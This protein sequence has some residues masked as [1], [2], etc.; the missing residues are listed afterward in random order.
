MTAAYIL[1]LHTHMKLTNTIV[2][3]GC[4]RSFNFMYFKLHSRTGYTE[5]FSAF[6]GRKIPKPKWKYI[7]PLS[8]IIVSHLILIWL[9]CAL[10]ERA[11]RIKLLPPYHRS[12]PIHIHRQTK[13][14]SKAKWK[15]NGRRLKITAIKLCVSVR[16]SMVCVRVPQAEGPQS[17]KSD[18]TPTTENIFRNIQP[19]G[20]QAG[21]KW[22][23][24][25]RWRAARRFSWRI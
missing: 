17:V 14:L 9:F 7:I 1:V 19:A 4:Q 10:A 2:I 5:Q 3:N 13:L 21:S 12:H 8:V 23:S 24:S 6:A 11:Y 25:R 20:R 22:V 15:M 16:E 18:R